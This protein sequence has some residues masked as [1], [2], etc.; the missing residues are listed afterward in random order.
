MA[1][2]KT[3]VTATSSSVRSEARVFLGMNRP[4]NAFCMSSNQW[5]LGHRTIILVEI[6]QLYIAAQNKVMKTQ[7]CCSLALRS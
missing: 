1:F 6:R 7:G 2:F 3:E 4:L 5:V